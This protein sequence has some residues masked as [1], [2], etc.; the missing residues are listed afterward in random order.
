MTVPSCQEV[1]EIMCVLRVTSAIL[2]NKKGP[3]TMTIKKETTLVMVTVSNQ[4]GDLGVILNPYGEFGNEWFLLC[5]GPYRNP[6]AIYKG[7]IEV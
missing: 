6:T 2:L 1:A 7:D 3:E 5:Q 4:E